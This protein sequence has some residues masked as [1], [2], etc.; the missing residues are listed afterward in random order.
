[1]SQPIEP[2]NFS[3]M[4]DQIVKN[5]RMNDEEKVIESEKLKKLLKDYSLQNV[6]ELFKKEI[7]N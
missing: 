7:V 1:M 3:K 5:L 6:L 4:A 2:Q